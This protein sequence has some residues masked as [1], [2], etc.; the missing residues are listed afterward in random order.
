MHQKFNLRN[1][2]CKIV[3][4]G[5]ISGEEVCRVAVGGGGVTV[6]WRYGGEGPRPPQILLYSAL[7]ITASF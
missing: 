6:G 7:A 4:H 3:G 1:G 5:E 2:L